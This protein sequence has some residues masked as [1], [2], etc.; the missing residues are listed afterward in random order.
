MWIVG[1]SIVS[2][3]WFFF[4]G[5]LEAV[6]GKPD[7]LHSPGQIITSAL[8]VPPDL[9]GASVLGWSLGVHGSVEGVGSI[10]ADPVGRVCLS[11][12]AGTFPCPIVVGDHPPTR[13]PLGLPLFFI[14]RVPSAA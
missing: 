10:L 8:G 2:V 14:S 11:Y 3:W 6:L 13:L 12:Q 7:T 1:A 4:L 5:L 9:R